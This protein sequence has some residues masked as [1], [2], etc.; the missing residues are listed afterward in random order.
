MIKKTTFSIAFLALPIALYAADEPK[1]VVIEAES[2]ELT[3]GA[4]KGEHVNASNGAYVDGL[5]KWEAGVEWTGIESPAGEAKLTIHYANGTEGVVEKSVEVNG[6]PAGTISF[7]TTAS[8]N[9]YDGK[10]TVT[11]TLTEGDNAIKIWRSGSGGDTG[12]VRLDAVE[13]VL[14]E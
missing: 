12:A 6:E 11:L 1:P 5:N 4:D 2:G 8:W 9:A 13:I 7:P 3:S 14:P 10:A